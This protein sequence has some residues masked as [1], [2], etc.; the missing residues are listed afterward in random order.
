MV[1]VHGEFLWLEESISIDFNLIAFITGL[2]SMGESLMQYMEDKTKEKYIVEEMKK[3]YGIE[4]G[5]HG[6]IIKIISDVAM[7]MA[8]NIMA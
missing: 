3:T 6:I 1:V 5:S 2:S 8:I 4:R 7:I